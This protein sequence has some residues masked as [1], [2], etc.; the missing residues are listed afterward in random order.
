MYSWEVENGKKDKTYEVIVHMNLC[1]E[2]AWI[3]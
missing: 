2:N 1:V 3:F